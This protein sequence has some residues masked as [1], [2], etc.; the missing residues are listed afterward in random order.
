M[1]EC[2]ASE[3]LARSLVP[4]KDERHS[5]EGGK[6]DQLYVDAVASLRRFAWVEYR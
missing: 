5:V 3:L 1:N 4:D 6:S 2:V